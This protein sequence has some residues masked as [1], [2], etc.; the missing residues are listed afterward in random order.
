MKYTLFIIIILA[1]TFVS[2]ENDYCVNFALND[3]SPS[4]V[5]ID[6]NFTLGIVLESCGIKAPQVTFELINYN[7]DIQI[8]ENLVRVIDDLSYGNSKRF[9]VYH[10]KTTK[11]ALPGEH[12]FNYRIKYGDNN[13]ELLKEGEFSVTVNG[14]KAKLSIASVKTKPTLPTQDQSTDLTFRI[15]NY[16]KGSANSVIVNLDHSFIGLKD[17]FIG[18][19]EPNQD[20]PAVFTFIPSTSG[21]I[22]IP[23]K[24]TYNDDYGD[25]EFNT[26][27]TLS[28]LAKKSNYKEIIIFLV[29]IIIIITMIIYTLII[30]KRKDKTIQQL[31]NGIK[32]K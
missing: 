14:E 13:V 29:L 26:K 17:S 5:S 27:I 8:K 7:K 9:L 12:F 31:L 18:K 11:E 15:E 3:V 1:L 4:S 24:I 32:K 25:N 22:E 16:G 23:V 20:G 28:V 30:K 6:S 10:M 21:E 19:L 2:A